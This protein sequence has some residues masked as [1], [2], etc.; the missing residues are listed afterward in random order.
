TNFTFKAD[1]CVLKHLDTTHRVG[2]ATTR[3]E[4]GGVLVLDATIALRKLTVSITNY[5][6]QVGL[7]LFPSICVSGDFVGTVESL[8]LRM[9]VAL[10]TP[11][12][13]ELRSLSITNMGPPQVHIT[14]LGVWT[15]LWKL[16]QSSLLSRSRLENFIIPIFERTKVREDITIQTIKYGTRQNEIRPR[17]ST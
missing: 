13:A 10:T 11:F 7:W 15:L 5:F 4:S 12:A 16:L 6:A 14:G 2:C 1:D 8:T 17:E 3:E 9:E